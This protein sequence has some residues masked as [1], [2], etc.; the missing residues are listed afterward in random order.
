MHEIENSGTTVRIAAK[1]CFE[2]QTP[3]LLQRLVF[4]SEPFPKGPAGAKSRGDGDGMP[5]AFR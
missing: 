4:Q 5:A 3:L 2:K 1:A